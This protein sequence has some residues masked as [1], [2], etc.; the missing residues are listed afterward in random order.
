MKPRKIKRLRSIISDKYYLAQRRDYMRQ[1]SVFWWHDWLFSRDEEDLRASKR[2]ERK[3]DW[4]TRRM[5][6]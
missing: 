4:Y 6:R 5:G 2:F 1:E 3:A